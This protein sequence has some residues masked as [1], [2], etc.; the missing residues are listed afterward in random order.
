MDGHGIGLG[1]DAML[2]ETF[3]DDDDVLAFAF[4]C[5]WMDLGLV[6]TCLRWTQTA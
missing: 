4:F 6:L 1:H 2:N 3:L 5:L